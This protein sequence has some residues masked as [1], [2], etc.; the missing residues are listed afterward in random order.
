MMNRQKHLLVILE[1]ECIEVAKEVPKLNCYIIII[2]ESLDEIK[3]NIES[4][5]E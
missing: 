1:E 4:K 5:L 3:N 2:G